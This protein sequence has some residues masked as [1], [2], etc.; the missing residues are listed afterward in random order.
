M[1]SALRGEA[2]TADAQA[3]DA[4]QFATPIGARALLTMAQHARGLAG[5]AEGHYA[6]AY[7]QLRRIHDRTDPAYHSFM[8]CFSVADLVDAAVHS[9]QTDAARPIVAELEALAG[10]TP[11]PLLH[12]GLAYVRPLL[13]N[14]D[15]AEALFDTAQ[16]SLDAWPFLRAR[17]QLAR[18]AWLRRHRRA[19]ESRAP[20]RAA[21]DAFDALGTIPWSERARREL[22]ASGEASRRRVPEARDQL[23]PQELQIA[24]MAAEGLTN[25]EIAQRLYIS[26]RTVSSHLYRIFPKL[27]ITSRSE[28]GDAIKAAGAGIT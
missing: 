10:R 19:A 18:G 3:A 4:E 25:P 16:R 17:A 26:R 14:G 27:G 23:T 21:R 12:A 9:A 20:L 7:E 28:L 11:A 15:D 13:A 24:Q 2:R 1:L 6:Q 22:R 8:R 5:L